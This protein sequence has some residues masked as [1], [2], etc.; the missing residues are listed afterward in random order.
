MDTI[1]WGHPHSL[2]VPVTTIPDFHK[3]L[4]KAA[5]QKNPHSKIT[6]LSMSCKRSMNKMSEMVEGINW[7]LL[8]FLQIWTTA[9]TTLLLLWPV[10][11]VIRTLT[12]ADWVLS[13]RCTFVSHCNTL[14]KVKIRGAKIK[15]CPK[16]EQLAGIKPISTDS[17]PWLF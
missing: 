5:W 13:P 8:V 7:I 10:S 11:V 1:Y 15:F 14:Q 12:T 4:R 3:E 9:T 17:K 16:P 6:F 2:V